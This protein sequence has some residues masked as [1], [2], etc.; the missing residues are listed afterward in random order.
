MSKFLFLAIPIL[1]LSLA[2]H[3]D[4]KEISSGFLLP[5]NAQKISSDI[6]YLGKAFDASSGKF[7]EGIAI[8]RRKDS[9]A[10][11]PWAG[12]GNSGSGSSCYSFL[13]KGA[14]WKNMESWVV[15]SQDSGLDSS[16]VLANIESNIA[17]WESASSSQILG[18]GELTNAVLAA[19]TQSTDGANEVYFDT[20]SDSN[21]IAVT[22]IWGIF[23]GP[24]QGRELVEWDQVYN[25]DYAWREDATGSTTHMDF[26]NISTHELGHSVGLGDLYTNTCV[27]E[28]MY[29]YST[30]GEVSKRD[31]GTGDIAG[32]N[33]LY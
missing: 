3:V 22:I 21:T 13:S 12:G 10:K 14:K 25:T 15:N 32:I 2:F 26:E 23:S 29:G 1:L 20:I 7:V 28:T 31:L 6:Y 11:P 33:E 4:A 18:T 27:N 17:K 30:E 9:E 8:V 5:E 19:N 24:P 16:F